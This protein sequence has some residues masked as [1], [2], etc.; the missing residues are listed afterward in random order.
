MGSVV[1]SFRG[2]YADL[3]G[4]KIGN[5]V[6][7]SIAG[8]D[9]AKAPVWRLMCQK[10]KREQLLSHSKLTVRLESQFA[11]ET[12]LCQNAACP[13]SR[14]DSVHTETLADVHKQERQEQ[15]KAANARQ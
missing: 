12:L 15:Q 10:C 1:T 8:R 3:T 6:V 13:L 5:F 9:R 4:Y 11:T 14:R 7:R 2:G